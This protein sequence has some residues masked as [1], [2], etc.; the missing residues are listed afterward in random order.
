VV[1]RRAELGYFDGFIVR[2]PKVE[3]VGCGRLWLT[4]ADARTLAHAATPPR[5]LS[6]VRLTDEPDAVALG[7]VTYGGLHVSD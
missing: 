4:D 6:R 1:E 2:G 5:S 7:R 3:R